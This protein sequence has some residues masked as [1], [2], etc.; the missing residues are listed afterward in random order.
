MSYAVENFHNTHR[1]DGAVRWNSNGQCLPKDCV[2]DLLDANLISAATAERTNDMREIEL[3]E[4][5]QNYRQA[6]A[7]RTAEQIQEERAMARGAMG[8]GV[9]MVNVITGETFY[10]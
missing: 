7:N 6:Q 9:K 2:Q 10:T 4:F 8:S 5:F 1:K 3:I